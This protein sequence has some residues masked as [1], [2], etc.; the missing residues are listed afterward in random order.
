MNR[1]VSV[2]SEYIRHVKNPFENLNAANTPTPS[3]VCISLVCDGKVLFFHSRL[4]TFES[5]QVLDHLR[6]NPIA[7]LSTCAMIQGI[8]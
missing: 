3:Q 4:C 2:M 8:S 5:A 6:H 7:V 1:R